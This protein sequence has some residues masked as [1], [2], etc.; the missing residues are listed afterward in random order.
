MF[1]T[2]NINFY[3]RWQYTFTGIPGLQTWLA[4]HCYI[5]EDFFLQFDCSI[6]SCYC[7]WIFIACIRW[8]ALL[9]TARIIATNWKGPRA[10]DQLIK[11]LQVSFFFR[12]F[13]KITRTF[14]WQSD[15][16]Y[17]LPNGIFFRT[18]MI[19]VLFYCLERNFIGGFFKH[20]VIFENSSCKKD[21]RK[22]SWIGQHFSKMNCKLLWEFWK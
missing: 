10:Y 16:N 4:L 12:K 18:K 13:D 5:K 2:L 19:V 21:W 14:S 9:R 11:R 17:L 3:L 22:I 7:S 6:A 1:L 20:F 8:L 15:E